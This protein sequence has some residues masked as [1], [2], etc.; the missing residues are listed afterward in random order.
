MEVLFAPT[1]GQTNDYPVCNATYSPSDG[2]V[3]HHLLPFF[4]SITTRREVFVESI[5][6]FVQNL[7]HA[8]IDLSSQVSSDNGEIVDESIARSGSEPFESKDFVLHF[9]SRNDVLGLLSK[10]LGVFGW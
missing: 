5:A 3:N 7:G 6:D 2:V 9:G 1:D 10:P 4:S 8:S